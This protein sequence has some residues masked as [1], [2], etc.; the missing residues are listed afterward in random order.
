[1]TSVVTVVGSHSQIISLPYTSPE[2]AILAQQLAAAIS[3]QVSGGSMLASSDAGGPPPPLSGQ[4]GEYEQTRPGAP[5]QLPLGYT[6]F[7]ETAPVGVVFGSSD[8]NQTI[9]SGANSSL[10][11]YATAGSG[12]VAAGGGNNLISIAN[13]DAGNWQIATDSGNDT[14]RA[15]G[16]GNDTIDAGGGNNTITLGGG[17]NTVTSAG[18][19]TITGTTGAETINA[20]TAQSDIVF[21]N[22]SDI[23]FVGGAGGATV[24]GGAGSDTYFGGTGSGVVYG[25]TAG[26]NYLAAGAGSSTLVGGGG[27]DTLVGGSGGATLTAGSNPS[28]DLFTFINGSAGGTDLVTGFFNPS[29]VH[30]ALIGYGPNEAVNAVANQ[31]SGANSVTIT[32]SDNTQV[33]FQNIT[34]LTSGNFQ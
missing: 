15:L 8:Q 30:I 1:M 5:I 18:N 28:T 22:S 2:T 17:A 16:G 11:F 21:G 34:H 25:G 13:T 19:D 14:I 27:N 31:V 33:T 32:L 12:T 4:T 3:A 24:I 20:T 6:A 10:T 29:D 9:L 7:I 26:S 23:V